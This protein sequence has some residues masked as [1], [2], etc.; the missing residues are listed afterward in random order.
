MFCYFCYENKEQ[1]CGFRNCKYSKGR[2]V[3][4]LLRSFPPCLM[5]NFFIHKLISVTWLKTTICF[6][7]LS[8]VK[9][10][11]KLIEALL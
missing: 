8:S 6:L 1:Q 9:V 5:Q 4:F 7:H 2:L 3:C 10:N 11:K